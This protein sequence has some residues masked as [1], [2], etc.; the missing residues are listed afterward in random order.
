ML[1]GELTEAALRQL[2][3]LSNTAVIT[4]E[5]KGKNTKC[6]LDWRVYFR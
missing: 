6:E 3:F 1:T 4:K 5:L 2:T